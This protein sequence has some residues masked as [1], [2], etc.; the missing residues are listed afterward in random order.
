[1]TATRSTLPSDPVDAIETPALLLDLDAFEANCRSISGH[2][3]ARGV[4]LAPA[5]QG[6]SLARHRTPADGVRRDRSHGREGF[7]GRG[8]GRRRH[9]Q[10]PRHHGTADHRAVAAAG[11]TAGRRRCDRAVDHPKQVALAAEA[12]AT[13]GTSIPVAVDVD[14][15]INRSGVQP[16]EPASSWRD[17]SPRLRGC[18]WP[19]SS[20]TKDT[21]SGHG[22][23]RTRSA[24]SGRRSPA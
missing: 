12:A 17:A 2:L 18:D 1:M 22:R 19:G 6:P 20:A 23:S 24:P 15:G 7:R 10:H 21:S 9:P 4:R 14:L 13:T 11:A 16:G 3:S 8:D 5:C